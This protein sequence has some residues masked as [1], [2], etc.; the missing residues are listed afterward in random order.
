MENKIYY[1]NKALVILIYCNYLVALVNTNLIS[2]IISI[3]LIV[4]IG[5]GD[6]WH[7]KK[8]TEDKNEAIKEIR[9]NIQEIRNCI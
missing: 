7:D 9:E 4:L 3:I 1:I 5:M 2:I 6:Y 8:I